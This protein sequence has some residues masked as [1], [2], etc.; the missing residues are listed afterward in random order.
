MESESKRALLA[1]A[2]AAVREA[3]EVGLGG[4]PHPP[5]VALPPDPR[6][7]APAA[8]FVSLHDPEGHVRGCVGTTAAV[9][10][11]AD[12][13]TEM[14]EAASLR[15][16]RFPPVTPREVPGL[17]IE[18]SVLDVP[19]KIHSL[20]DI[21]IGRDGLIVVGRGR[22]GLLLPQVAE[23]HGWDARTFVEHT[24]IK[25]GLPPTAFEAGDAELFRFGAEVFSESCGYPAE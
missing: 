9:R 5:E 22:R 6:I 4:I 16:P 13:V 1:L 20:D 7:T 18:I 15:D 3:A 11:L 19:T 2:R 23:E 12:V 21:V 17:E 10:P 24:C 8:A 14:A 25:A